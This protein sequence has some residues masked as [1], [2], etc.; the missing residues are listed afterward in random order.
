MISSILLLF[1]SFARE[2]KAEEGRVLRVCE[3]SVAATFISPKGTVL[4]FPS[5]PEKVFLGTK[6]TFS[7]DYIRSDLVVSPLSVL[8]RSNLFVYIHGRRFVFALSTSATSG[9]TFYFIK[10]C[11]KDLA[12]EGSKNRKRKP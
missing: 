12:I 4:E 6:S 10:D 3:K 2:V 7:I 8:A 5:E 11:E 9:A 1:L